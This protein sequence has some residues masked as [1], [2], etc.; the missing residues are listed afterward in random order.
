MKTCRSNFVINILWGHRCFAQV[1]SAAK[2]IYRGDSPYHKRSYK[3]FEFLVQFP[4]GC[5]RSEYVL[6]EYGHKWHGR[7]VSA[8]SLLY[9]QDILSV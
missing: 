3:I 8:F 4:R 5:P 1:I 9:V 2:Y 6:C 7:M